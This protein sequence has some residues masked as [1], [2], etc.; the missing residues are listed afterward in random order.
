MLLMAL[1]KPLNLKLV[2]TIKIKGQA[3]LIKQDFTFGAA[4]LKNTVGD[5]STY[6][7]PPTHRI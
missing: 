1:L 4:T 3:D 7:H 5:A 6:L 2:K